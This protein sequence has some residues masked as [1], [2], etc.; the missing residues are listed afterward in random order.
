M[1]SG[2]EC[3]QKEGIKKMGRGSSG[4]G[5]S[6]VPGVKSAYTIVG[7]DGQ[8]TEWYFDNAGGINYYKTSI[9]GMPNPTPGQ[10]DSG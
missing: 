8:R 5:G 6:R 4:L 10:Y 2:A 9:D 1:K 3:C 7:N